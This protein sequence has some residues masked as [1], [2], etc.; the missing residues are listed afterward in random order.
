MPLSGKVVVVTGAGSG[1]GRAIGETVAKAGGHVV[2][3]GRRPEILQE[4]ADSFGRFAGREM[5]AIPTDI[6]RA[7]QVA[8]AIDAALNRFGCIDALVNNAG[9]AHF[10]PIDQADLADLEIMLDVHLRGPIHLI[11]SALPAL[12]RSAG[13]IVN[14]SS[15]GGILALPGRV[16]YGATKAALN[17][18][19][20]SLARELAPAVRVNAIIPGPVVTPI[21]SNLQL[22]IEDLRSL[23]DELI[24]TTPAGRFGRPEEVARWVCS[25]ID[26][27]SRWVTGALITVDGGRSC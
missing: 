6:G 15:I 1:I 21:Y 18:L 25:L 19:T 26:D 8:H 12:K 11:R 4:A 10:A 27:E 2:A 16:L 14:V 9:V 24:R 23:E 7:D 13:N 20:R 5:L 17:H 3:L 22:S